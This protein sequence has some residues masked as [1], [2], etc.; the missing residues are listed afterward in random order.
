MTDSEAIEHF[1]ATAVA[2]VREMRVCDAA[3]FLRGL[4]ILTEDRP[5]MDRVR[6]V[7]TDLTHAD[8]QLE[9]IASGKLR[10]QPLPL[11]R[12][13]PPPARAPHHERPGNPSE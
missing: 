5:E 10:Q 13:A 3:P 2:M 11:D 7:Y 8:E 4:M 1:E 6:R 12:V 9:L